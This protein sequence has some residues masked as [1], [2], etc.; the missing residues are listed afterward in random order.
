MGIV[1]RADLVVGMRLHALIMAAA[2]GAPFFGLAYDEKVRQ[3]CARWGAP[4][5]KTLPSTR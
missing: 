4:M 5:A 3:H 2:T 1:A